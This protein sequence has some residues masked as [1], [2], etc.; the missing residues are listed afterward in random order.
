[1]GKKTPSTKTS[2]PSPNAMHV[3][4]LLAQKAG[5]RKKVIEPALKAPKKPSRA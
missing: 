1:M 5:N 4:L 3:L 2:S